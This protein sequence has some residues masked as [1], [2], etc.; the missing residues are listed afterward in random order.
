MLIILCLLIL[1]FSIIYCAKC[2][3]LLPVNHVVE[4]IL[5]VYS[6]LVSCVFL[7]DIGVDI[8]PEMLYYFLA[9][10]IEL[11][12]NYILYINELKYVIRIKY[13]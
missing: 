8:L 12:E 13:S 2:L 3:Y 1:I 6:I 4:F 11:Y 10:F 5:T 9:R 7:I